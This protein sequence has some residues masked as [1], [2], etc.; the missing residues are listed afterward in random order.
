MG[1]GNLGQWSVLAV[2][3]VLAVSVDHDDKA[4]RKFLEKY[5]PAFLTARENKVHAEYGTFMY[6]E[7]YIIDSQGKVLKK[8]AEAVDW[9]DPG[10]TQYIDSL[11]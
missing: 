9:L 4:Y 5:K 10:V 7:T 3:V 2:V 11:L 6:P 8:F 1:L